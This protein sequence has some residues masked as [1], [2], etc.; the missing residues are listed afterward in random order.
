MK[1][2]CITSPRS[3]N[4]NTD[5]SG[6]L[7]SIILLCD[8]PGYR[9]KSYGP[10]PLI[11]ISNHKLIDLQIKA[12]QQS[13]TNFELIICLGF[14][15]EKTCKY[16]RSKYSK[17]PIRIV[18]NQL[19]NSSNSCESVRIALNN[20]LNSK[21]LICSGNLLF[22]NKIFSLIH[23]N[24]TCALIENDPCENLEIGINVD[25]NNE[26]QYFSFGACK[27]WS[28]ILYLHDANIVET[29]R[30]IIVYPD[31]KNKF[32]FEALNDVLKSKH[33]I[34]CINNKYPIKKINN[35]K[36]Y[37]SMREQSK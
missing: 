27:I 5:L 29:L 30:K 3:L 4:K 12:I 15:A 32:I 22:S 8:S 19:F 11:N 26:A 36:T 18:E 25:N 34:T 17:L 10:L 2:K 6:E 33:K 24:K 13:F 23:Y 28:E 1:T 16:I 20:T 9:M 31:N 37:H 35:I 7:I 14:D 21:V